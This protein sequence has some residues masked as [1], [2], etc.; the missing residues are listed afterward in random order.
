MRAKTN[1][2]N[3]THPER[4]AHRAKM[5]AAVRKYLDDHFKNGGT[6]EELKNTHDPRRNPENPGQHYSIS[7]VRLPLPATQ[8]GLFVIK[9]LGDSLKSAFGGIVRDKDGGEIHV[10]EA[11][12]LWAEANV[13]TFLGTRTD[14]PVPW[15][16]NSCAADE[17]DPE[18]SFIAMEYI[19]GKVFDTRMTLTENQKS[20]IIRQVAAIRIRLMEITSRLIGG[21]NWPMLPD[22]TPAPMDPGDKHPAGAMSGPRV[23]DDGRVRS[24]PRSF[25]FAFQID[26]ATNQITCIHSI[27]SGII[28]N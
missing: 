1:E 24:P 26:I 19:E 14:I 11:R 5:T 7:I 28:Q 21:A 6:L 10:L 3:R 9:D 20:S 27:K 13:M 23:W 18:R 12:D 4:R 15:I 8:D 16:Y 22:G 25:K 2:R 17:K